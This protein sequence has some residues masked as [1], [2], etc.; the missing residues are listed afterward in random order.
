MKRA[1]VCA[2]LAATCATTLC[3]TGCNGTQQQQPAV[4]EQSQEQTAE[5]LSLTGTW[6]QTNADGDTVMEAVI[7]GKSITINW[8]SDG[9]DIESLY[10]K[11]S[12]KAPADDVD[13]YEWTSKGDTKA[14]STS[15]LASTDETKDFVY[16]D[17]Q[18]TYKASA[19]GTTKT[20]R[21][22]LKD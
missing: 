18:L 20:V 21:M 17:G 12:Y 11:G 22:A 8:V 2:T 9:G 4:Q 16:K 1:F 19:L 14:M 15:L 3:I 7:K 6:E 10:W 5:P 13:S